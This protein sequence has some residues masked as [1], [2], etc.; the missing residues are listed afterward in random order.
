ML[1]I[2]QTD[3]ATPIYS[4]GLL[5]VQ[6]LNANGVS[7]SLKAN[8]ATVTDFTT[9][10]LTVNGTLNP[11]NF[12]LS[13]LNNLNVAGNFTLPDFPNVDVSLGEIASRAILVDN[14][15][16]TTDGIASNFA[17]LQ[18]HYESDT[19][20]LNSKD[21][22]ASYQISVQGDA[23][24]DALFISKGGIPLMEFSTRGNDL[25]SNSVKFNPSALKP[26]IVLMVVDDLPFN[27]I[28]CYGGAKLAATDIPAD[29][30]NY[31]FKAGDTIIATPNIDALA[32]AGLKFTNMFN[33]AACSPT[34]ATIQTGMYPI[35]VGSSDVR[36]LSQ[37]Y[38]SEPIGDHNLR[39]YQGNLLKEN[40]TIGE[41]AKA[42][43]Y[44]TFYG[45]KWHLGD[46]TSTLPHY[47]NKGIFG[48]KLQNY[49][50][51]PT[52]R[53]YDYWDAGYTGGT[54]SVLNPLKCNITGTNNWN[55]QDYVR[56]PSSGIGPGRVPSLANKWNRY[57]SS[58]KT[59]G[60]QN[61]AYGAGASFFT[62]VTDTSF[63]KVSSNFNIPDASGKAGNMD[64]TGFKYHHN[65][66]LI[67]SVM[68]RLNGRTDKTKPFFID[69][70]FSTVHDPL[71]ELPFYIKKFWTNYP[72]EPTAKTC[73]FYNIGWDTYRTR[74]LTAQRANGVIIPGKPLPPRS[75]LV[76]AW[77]N[78][79]YADK[80][81]NAKSMAIIAAMTVHMDDSVGNFVNY[82]KTE[83]LFNN[84]MIMFMS[85][86]GGAGNF[87]EFATT[88]PAS[89]GSGS[90]GVP[91][92]DASTN[93]T[94]YQEGD[95]NSFVLPGWGWGEALNYP[96]RLV[97]AYPEKGGVQTPF[98]VSWPNGIPPA[99]NGSNVDRYCWVEDIFPTMFEICK[100]VQ[101]AVNSSSATRFN[102]TQKRIIYDTSG[103]SI[104]PAANLANYVATLPSIKGTSILPLIKG[105]SPNIQIYRAK[106]EVSDLAQ[107]CGSS[108][109]WGNWQIVINWGFKTLN[110]SNE[111]YGVWRL[112]NTISDPYQVNDL[113][114]QY[115]EKYKE[116][117][118]YYIDF[119]IQQQTSDGAHSELYKLSSYVSIYNFKL[120]NMIDT[121]V[122]D[123]MLFD[124][125]ASFLPGAVMPA[126][127][128]KFKGNAEQLR[129]YPDG[130]GAH[131]TGIEKLV[132]TK[133]ILNA[134]KATVTKYGSALTQDASGM[135]AGNTIVNG[136]LSDP[137][138]KSTLLCC[139]SGHHGKCIGWD[140]SFNRELPSL[141]TLTYF[142]D[143]A[144]RVVI[145]VN[146]GMLFFD[147][148]GMSGGVPIDGT[149]NAFN[150]ITDT[151]NSFYDPLASTDASGICYG[152]AR[153]VFD[154]PYAEMVD[155][156]ETGFYLG[157]NWNIYDNYN[158]YK[159]DTSGNGFSL[160]ASNARV[161]NDSSGNRSPFPPKI[162]KRVVNLITGS[163]TLIG[164]NKSLSKN[165]HFST[166]Q[167]GASSVGFCIRFNVDASNNLDVNNSLS[168][169]RLIDIPFGN[170]NTTTGVTT[171]NSSRYAG[172]Y[173]IVKAN[174]NL[175]G[176][177][178]LISQFTGTPNPY[179]SVN[180]NKN[181]LSYATDRQNTTNYVTFSVSNAVEG[182]WSGMYGSKYGEY[183]NSNVFPNAY[184]SFG[185]KLNKDSSHN[186]FPNVYLAQPY[187]TGLIAGKTSLVGRGTL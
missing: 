22:G 141:P 156:T 95:E 178:R 130:S 150:G 160:D 30:S 45:G 153:V 92:Y 44:S 105:D 91:Y 135:Y 11:T 42:G 114:S 70:N 110:E 117:K 187:A 147:S 61:N 1:R 119:C 7:A 82:L 15:V 163:T 173:G 106:P 71:Q 39:G 72:N 55:E 67:Y 73:V 23:S 12:N 164:V 2:H 5:N 121:Y 124:G 148:S 18:T 136:K 165:Y 116:M 37:Q 122:R 145:Y 172:S 80:I 10:N 100:P 97:K 137:Y 139:N 134:L 161:V 96:F 118:Q 128:W 57:I 143:D 111:P 170:W 157:D 24:G 29:A 175:D 65:D 166:S 131:Q 133:N 43:G 13:A 138:Y 158:E 159:F 126:T 152:R 120:S 49:S 25:S 151:S 32:A 127:G 182:I 79:T 179:F 93:P 40:N 174:D 56:D 181:Y 63:F 21:G 142:Y 35:E 186:Y 102:V 76:N 146:P 176:T 17:A 123:Q 83:G 48:L 6:T 36:V 59:A 169:G 19:I 81:I 132:P 33:Q 66:D 75:E 38:F 107:A 50:E 129:L 184:A 9:T 27:V 84:T 64:G 108:V 54:M 46:M 94:G 14:I 53:G 47:D 86:N 115:P 88:P 103:L 89:G 60:T 62:A 171:P 167:L 8:T 99:R 155:R 74:I 162:A 78:L 26:N 90:W 77:E 185:Y 104:I 85:D 34:R 98:V 109:T 52:A 68:N 144:L 31:G 113:A 154:L 87:S 140:S 177:T 41:L 125:S 3:M 4:A 51:F 149:Y 101:D 58:Y 28:G 183:F 69:M 16:I 20:T 180:G 112:Y 168:Y